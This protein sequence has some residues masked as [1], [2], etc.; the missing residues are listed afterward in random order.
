MGERMATNHE[1]IEDLRAQHPNFFHKYEALAQHYY[2]YVVSQDDNAIPRAHVNALLELLAQ[3]GYKLTKVTKED[4]V[5]QLTD[6]VLGF[7]KKGN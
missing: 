1:I 2:K 4:N 7:K 5:I 6:N 3:S